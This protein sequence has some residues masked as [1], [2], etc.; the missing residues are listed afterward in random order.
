MRV[1]Q[2]SRRHRGSACV[3]VGVVAPRGACVCWQRCQCV[4]LRGLGSPW[5]PPSPLCFG[6]RGSGH[7]QLCSVLMRQ[8][9]RGPSCAC[10]PGR[11]RG[12]QSAPPIMAAK[13]Q[14][15]GTE[16]GGGRSAPPGAPEGEDG[17]APTRSRQ[18]PPG[19]VLGSASP[20]RWL[21]KPIQISLQAQSPSQALLPSPHPARC[22]GPAPPPSPAPSLLPLADFTE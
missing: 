11:G 10:F 18:P 22:Q 2:F 16:T 15:E 6:A 3:A 8:M 17:P 19:C 21:L 13:R 14:G 5:P 9:W 7:T 4:C 12:L 1:C 20:P